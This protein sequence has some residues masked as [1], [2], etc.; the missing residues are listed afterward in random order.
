MILTEEEMVSQWLLRKGYEPLRSDCTIT[1]SDGND[2]QALAALECH[3]WYEKLLTEAPIELLV[4]HDLAKSKEVKSTMT[5]ADSIMVTLPANCVR[6]VAVKLGS[7][8]APARIVTPDSPLARRQYAPFS[9]AGITNPVA[10]WHPNNKLELF[11][12]AYENSDTLETLLCI[13]R[14]T[15]AEDSSKLIYEF[16]P[17][18]LSTI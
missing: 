14:Q 13:V 17:D 2:L 4:P 3:I 18:A 11:S 15:D 6:P 7:W 5:L 9:A 8:L 12:P 10:I 16:Q 1:R